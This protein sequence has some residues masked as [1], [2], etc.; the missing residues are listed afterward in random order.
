MDS[1]PTELQQVLAEG[2]FP[3]DAGVC[4]VRRDSTPPCAEYDAAARQ[5]E[6]YAQEA[7]QS[8]ANV[9]QALRTLHCSDAG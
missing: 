8:L 9:W 3:D 7:G 4:M 6:R 5:I 2:F 1:I